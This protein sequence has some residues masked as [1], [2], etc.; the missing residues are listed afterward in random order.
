ME[1]N[2]ISKRELLDLT[3]IS[4]GQLYRWKRKQLIPEDWFIKKSSFTGQETFFPK[5]EILARID[6]IVNMKED[7]SLD[8][9]AVKV[10][11]GSV[12][13]RMTAQE[14]IEKQIINDAN[15]KFITD[16]FGELESYPF[17]AVLFMFIIDR[18][19]RSGNINLDEGKI[20]LQVLMDNFDKFND[21]PCELVFIR[22]LGI[23]SC[24]LNQ[25]SNQ[26]IFEKNTNIIFR[27]II[28]SCIE[29]LKI[30]LT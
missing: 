17:D 6:K 24:L 13:I 18:L 10:S 15:L 30:K 11:T 8:D 1:E 19:F 21:K 2:L 27:L 4:Y 28:A 26:L 20:I 5:D 29:E 9:I 25:S 22:K 12:N 7:L 3:G 16:R 23:S 14:L